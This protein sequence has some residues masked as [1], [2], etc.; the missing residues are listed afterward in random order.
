MMLD[1]TLK[2]LVQAIIA[3]PNQSIR[4]NL[5]DQLIYQ[6]TGVA[7]VDPHS[8]DNSGYGHVM[9]ARQLET[10]IGSQYQGTW[11]DGHKD[12]NPHGLAA[13]LLIAEYRKFKYYTEAQLLAHSDP[14][15]IMGVVDSLFFG[16]GRTDYLVNWDKLNE[17]LTNLIATGERDKALV[18]VTTLDHLGI[19][20]SSYQQQKQ[21]IINT[22]SD[23]GKLLADLQGFI[24]ILNISQ[25]NWLN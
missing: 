17:K 8:R 3:E 7:K 18:I 6:W 15:L 1:S 11:C 23:F 21:Q 22:G 16:S 5:L 14:E 13:S 9:D 25:T 12:P 19:Y 24:N 4:D 2:P 10:L 20:T